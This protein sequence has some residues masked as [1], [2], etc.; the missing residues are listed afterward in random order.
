[1]IQVKV[2]GYEYE[3]RGDIDRVENMWLG[4]EDPIVKG[5]G[6]EDTEGCSPDIKDKL[7]TGNGRG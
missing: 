2:S 7:T 1:M 3:Y 5:S 4:V 6:D